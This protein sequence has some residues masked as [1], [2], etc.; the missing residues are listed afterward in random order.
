MS[1]F[2]YIKVNIFEPVWPRVTNNK[3]N[4]SMLALKPER[5]LN[6]DYF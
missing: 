2:I 1:L 3:Q 6:S 5:T 4:K